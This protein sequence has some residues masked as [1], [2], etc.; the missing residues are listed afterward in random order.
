VTRQPTRTEVVYDRLRDDIVTGLLAP[1]SKLRFAELND[2][3]GASMGVTREA[4]SRL[5]EQGFVTSEPQ[6][7]FRVV[8]L[9]AADL[10]DLTETRCH[11][12]TQALLLAIEF[13]TVEWEA[14]LLAAHHA[15]TRTV[16][17][18]G[19][20]PSLAPA[21]TNAHER[22]HEALITGG[23]NVRLKAL[24][25]SLRANAEIYRSWSTSYGTERVIADEHRSICEAALDRDAIT[26]TDL[27]VEHL[28]ETARR[29]LV[30]APDADES[31]LTRLSRIPTVCSTGAQLFAQRTEPG[32][33]TGR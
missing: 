14:N 31:C 16:L 19:V 13:G 28:V 32:D 7:G 22:F 20:H 12:E 3:Y 27:L 9:S 23:P 29:L 18:D 25:T 11:V 2:R 30:A 26:A 33:R 15:L 21:W 6:L 1:G 24:A 5:A 8:S 10:L 17:N 4:L